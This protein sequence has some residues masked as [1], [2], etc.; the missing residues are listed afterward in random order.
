MRIQHPATCPEVDP[1]LCAT[2]EIPLHEHDQH[3]NWSRTSV[4][5]D[6]GIT[7]RLQLGLYLPFDVRAVSVDYFLPDGTAYSPPY[8]DIHHRDETLVGL[9]DGAIE[10]KSSFEPIEGLILAGSIGSSLPLGRTEED[11]FALGASGLK[12]QHMQLG[13]GLP[14]PML[15]VEAAWLGPRV[16]AVGWASG[17]V[18]VAENSKGYRPPYSLNLGLGPTAKLRPRLDGLATA[19]LELSSP[20]TWS[21]TPYGGQIAVMGGVGLTGA[22]RPTLSLTGQARFLLFQVDH[23]EEEE[24]SLRQPV[25]LTLGLSWAPQPR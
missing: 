13:A 10:L 12:H 23:H 7:D 14:V 6:W 20:E 9:A 25:I 18:P 17:R 2:T 3:I 16:G 8:D 4:S 24:G 11:P 1:I 19:E 22:L 5:A 21:S 15:G